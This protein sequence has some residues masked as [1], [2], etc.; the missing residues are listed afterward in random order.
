MFPSRHVIVSLSAGAAF[1]FF[2]KSFYAGAVCF[3]AGVLSDIDHII[4]YIIHHGFKGVSIAKVYEASL[5]TMKQEGDR[6]YNKVYLIFHA[7]EFVLLLWI[8]A[9]LTGNIYLIAAALGY[10][11]HIGMDCVGNPMRVCSYLITWRAINDF[12]VQRLF[13]KIS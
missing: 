8:I 1:A 12:D 7:I 4:E 10:S 13:R 2:T 9:L 5:H 11:L 3:F 6:K